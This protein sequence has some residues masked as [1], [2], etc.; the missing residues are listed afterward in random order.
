LF[1]SFLSFKSPPE[2]LRNVS[3]RMAFSFL[4]QGITHVHFNFLSEEFSECSV[5][6]TVSIKTFGRSVLLRQ[7]VKIKRNVKNKGKRRFLCTL[8]NSTHNQSALLSQSFYSRVGAVFAL[9]NLCYV[10]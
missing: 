6:V 2:T 4:K 5:Q 10:R 7:Q 8:C 3:A 1:S 9:G